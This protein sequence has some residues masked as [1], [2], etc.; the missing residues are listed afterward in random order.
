MDDKAQCHAEDHWELE[1]M[2][3]LSAKLQKA[4]ELLSRLAAHPELQTTEIS[5]LEKAVANDEIKPEDDRECLLR[6][7]LLDLIYDLAYE[8]TKKEIQMLI[9][10]A[11]ANIRAILLAT[12][13]QVVDR[14]QELQ[15]PALE[16]ARK[17]K[18]RFFAD[19]NGIKDEGD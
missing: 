11:N 9:Q 4:V 12:E 15:R 5:K 16:A 14:V 13:A 18:R 1:R 6:E 17:R 10:G 8:R 19:A 7:T 3:P 2:N